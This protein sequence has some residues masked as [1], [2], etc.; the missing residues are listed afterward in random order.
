M[1][2]TTTAASLSEFLDIIFD[3]AF[4]TQTEIPFNRVLKQTDKL[5]FKYL[6]VQP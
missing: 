6:S 5:F 4:Y 1:V 2:Q 3:A